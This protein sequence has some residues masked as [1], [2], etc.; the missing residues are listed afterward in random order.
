MIKI[1]NSKKNNLNLMPLIILIILI[2]ILSFLNN[3]FLSLNTIINNMNQVSVIGIVAIGAMIVIISG[4]IDFSSGYGLAAIG[5]LSSFIYSLNILPNNIFIFALLFILFGAFIG[6][7][8]GFIITKFNILPFI[9]TLAM[10]S[11]MQGVSIFVNK[12]TMII[13]TEYDFISYLGHGKLFNIIPITFIVFVIISIFVS[14][15]MNKTK[16]GTYDYAIGGD[17][18]ALL[19]SGVNVKKYKI[20]IYVVAGICTGLASMLTVSQIGMATPSLAGSVLTDA[21]A[22]TCI[23]GTSMSGGKGNI[24][25]TVIGSFIIILIGT[26]LTYLNIAAEMQNVF[27]GCVILFAVAFDALFENIKKRR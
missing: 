16:F 24:F 1:N 14:V 20:L 12:G 10:M 4:G 6:F 21:I 25:G 27:K 22:A 17:E 15:I 23:G 19:Y 18:K 11:I 3:S 9:A 26:A 2:V 7:C 5:M 13:L 8:N